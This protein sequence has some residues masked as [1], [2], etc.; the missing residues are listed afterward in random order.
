MNLATDF[1]QRVDPV[2]LALRA[3]FHPYAWQ[4]EVLRSTSRQMLLN[5]S[6]QA[7]KSTVTSIVPLH[8]SLYDPG[9]LSLIVSPSERQ[10][11]LLLEKT[12]E[13]I[14][15]LGQHSI[16]TTENDLYCKLA[17]GSEIYALPGKEG[18]IRGF[19]D[20]KL[21][22]IDEASRA[23]DALY[24]A[25]RPMLATSGGRI[26][27]LST[28][29]GKR[30]FFHREWTEGGANWQRVHIKAQEVPHI[31]PEFLEEERASLP[32]E[33][34][35]QEYEGSFVD[36]LD[37]IFTHELVSG[38]MSS[39]VAPLFGGTDSWSPSLSDPTLPPLPSFSG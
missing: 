18:T 20:V 8:L 27:L 5:C 14:T 26:I 23:A 24:H 34:F 36:T 12:Y 16:L 22:I 30:G 25:V 28:P 37:Q 10:S 31:S 21:V 7:G 2:N 35:A 3:G 17:N 6:R 11:K 19:S 13:A 33:L 9:S 29:F 15:A 39:D 38:L 1:L 32:P 4:E